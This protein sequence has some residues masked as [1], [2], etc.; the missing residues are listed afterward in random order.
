VFFSKL[1][2][3]SPELHYAARPHLVSCKTASCNNHCF[4]E[5]NIL[6]SEDTIS[7]PRTT[8]P[9]RSPQT[10]CE[11]VSHYFVIVKL[12]RRNFIFS[13][14]W[15]TVSHSIE[16][17]VMVWLFVALKWCRCRTMCYNIQKVVVK[18]RSCSKKQL[19]WGF[20]RFREEPLHDSVGLNGNIFFSE[21]KYT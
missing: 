9:S 17:F 12:R 2:K 13:R 15:F 18:M 1:E 8:K 14:S 10:E 6:L 16:D 21:T 5:C 4:P 11:T 20:F 3:A 19:R 7:R